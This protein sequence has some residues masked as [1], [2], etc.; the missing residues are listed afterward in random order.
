[1][2]KAHST[3][4]DSAMLAEDAIKQAVVDKFPGLAKIDADRTLTFR[5]YGR[6]HL[7]DVHAHL[8]KEEPPRMPR[9][10]LLE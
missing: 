8:L 7:I 4:L 2:N 3:R 6:E 1:M 5:F 10:N 9:P